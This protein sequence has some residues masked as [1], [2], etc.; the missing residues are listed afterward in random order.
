VLQTEG[1][2]AEVSG[3]GGIRAGNGV[4]WVLG[5]ERKSLDIED[6]EA[7]TF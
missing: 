4:S 3:L 1:R 6:T 7:E 5:I 2:D